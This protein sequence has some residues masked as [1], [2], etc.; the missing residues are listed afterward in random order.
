MMSLQR[1]SKSALGFFILLLVFVVVVPFAT[2][3]AAGL[4]GNIQWR[5]TAILLDGIDT[6]EKY[7]IPVKEAV[8]FISSNSRLKIQ[9][10]GEVFDIPHTYTFYDCDTG[11]L[12]ARQ[13]ID[14]GGDVRTAAEKGTPGHAQRLRNGGSRRHPCR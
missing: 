14:R 3:A 13:S 9:F 7:S 5:A 11:L 10:S 4:P 6:T 8:N 1:F 12:P 2:E